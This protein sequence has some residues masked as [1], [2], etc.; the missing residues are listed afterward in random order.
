MRE[1]ALAA[2]SPARCAA[3][4]EPWWLLFS[5]VLAYKSGALIS[6]FWRFETRLV[7]H[8]KMSSLGRGEG[9][10]LKGT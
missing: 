9:V 1:A 5:S 10:M 6:L 7:G 2:S 8:V 3:G 4:N